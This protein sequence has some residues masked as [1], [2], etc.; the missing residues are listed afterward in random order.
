MTTKHVRAGRGVE[1]APTKAEQARAVAA[2]MRRAR[3]PSFDA[4]VGRGPHVAQFEA[5]LAEA[6]RL[7]PPAAVALLAS[8][9]A[10]A[11]ALADAGAHESRL[12][13]GAGH[14]AATFVVQAGERLV[15]LARHVGGAAEGALLLDAAHCAGLAEGAARIALA[16]LRDVRKGGRPIDE[17]RMAEI[18]RALAGRD[19]LSSVAIARITGLPERSIRA[20]RKKLGKN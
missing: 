12:A 7:L 17:A 6:A 19:H 1:P 14:E 13:G 5:E 20:Y 10:C 4:L 8:V 2:A 15:A 11:R 3:G 16:A 9:R 18:E